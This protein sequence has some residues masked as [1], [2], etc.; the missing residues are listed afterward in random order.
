MNK[1]LY[2]FNKLH[3]KTSRDYIARMVDDKVHCMEKAKVGEPPYFFTL[4]LVFLF[5]CHSI[6]L[7]QLILFVACY[8]VF[9]VPCLPLSLLSP[10]ARQSFFF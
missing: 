10:Y 3:K 5:F 7:Y 4:L 6:T 2:I 8:K 9:S 1:E